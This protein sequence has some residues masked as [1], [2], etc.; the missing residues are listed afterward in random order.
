MQ[1]EKSRSLVFRQRLAQCIA[2]RGLTQVALARAVG[3]S[4]VTINNYLR[5]VRSLPRAEELLAMAR[6]LEVTMEW[7]L[8]AGE[9]GDGSEPEVRAG[10]GAPA[11]PLSPLCAVPEAELRELARRLREQA[12][13]L[14]R[15][16]PGGE[17][18][19]GN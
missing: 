4:H 13:Q 19:G 8:G 2:E 3:V 17:R 16:C 5:G 10:E 15:H 1:P 7:L 11:G 18:Q 6:V 12:D 14:E 9:D